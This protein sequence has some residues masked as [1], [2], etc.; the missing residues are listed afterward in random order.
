MGTTK[1]NR[2]RFSPS[3]GSVWEDAG[4]LSCIRSKATAT[5]L[6]GK[7]FV[8]GG[9]DDTNLVLSTIEV[10]DN[11]MWKQAGSRFVF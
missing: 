1:V 6:E 4:K 9:V 3:G 11:S 7:V 8:L 2:F 5:E 10:W